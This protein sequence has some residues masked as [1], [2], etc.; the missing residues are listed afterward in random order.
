MGAH[1]WTNGSEG[2]GKHVKEALKQLDFTNGEDDV[3]VILAL[4]IETV[5][6]G[7]DKK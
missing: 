3:K 7:K 4:F 1:I 5:M 2:E 6:M